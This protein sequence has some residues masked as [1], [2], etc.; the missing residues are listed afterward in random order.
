IES[1]AGSLMVAQPGTTWATLNGSTVLPLG[2]GEID[3]HNNYSYGTVEMCGSTTPFGCINTMVTTQQA[4]ISDAITHI[5]QLWSYSVGNRILN[6]GGR[7][8][9]H[10]IQSLQPFTSVR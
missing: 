9:S 6:L 10:T 4:T 1:G 7:S 5:E 8:I 3:I 2:V